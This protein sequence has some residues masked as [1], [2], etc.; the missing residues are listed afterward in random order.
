MRKINKIILHCSATP[1]GKDYTVEQIDRWHK[2]RG[3]KK[4]GYHYVIYRDGS[5]KKGRDETEIGAHTT[6]QNS[7]SIGICYIGG[8]D[9]DNIKPKDTRTT[10]Q[11]DSLFL[12]CYNLMGKYNL[13]IDDIH[14]H[15]EYAKKAC[16]SFNIID[17]KWDYLKWVGNKLNQERNE[18]EKN[19]RDTSRV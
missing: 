18:I 7:D 11:I 17:F 16:P 5:I 13:R 4:I 14:A 6:G 9:K 10:E 2:Q 15:Y 1:E 3:F 8:M 12:L 19:F